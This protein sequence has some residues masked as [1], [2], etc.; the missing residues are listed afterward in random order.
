MLLRESGRLLLHEDLGH[1]VSLRTDPTTRTRSGNGPNSQPSSLL[2]RK[3][4]AARTQKPG[5]LAERYSTLDQNSSSSTCPSPC[6]SGLLM[7]AAADEVR[8]TRFSVPAL[9]H[10]LIT[11][12]VPRTAGSICSTCHARTELIVPMARHCSS[13][14]LSSKN[15]DLQQ[16][17]V[18]PHLR[19]LGLE[20]H[21][22]GD[23]E[24]VVAAGDGLI[25]A[26]F[27][28]QIR[29]EDLQLTKRLQVLEV[30]V[31]RHVI[32]GFQ[33]QNFQALG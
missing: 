18:L 10:D 19:I 11:F 17:S 5:L 7:I 25:E 4:T 24:D 16:N 1:R 3:G 20:V 15:R 6:S 8:I 31:L 30:V 22:T 12:K 23:E 33:N 29:A 21:G 27:L 26:P 9:A 13:C 28:V 32:W 14:W 2:R